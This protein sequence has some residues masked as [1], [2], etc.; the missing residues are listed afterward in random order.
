MTVGLLDLL[1][2][3]LVGITGSIVVN[4]L[5]S[6]S[7]GDRVSNVLEVLNLESIGFENQVIILTSIA[8]FFLILRTL[9]SVFVSQRVLLILANISA[10]TSVKIFENFI[11]SDIRV[12]QEKSGEESQFAIN[13]GSFVFSLNNFKAPIVPRGFFSSRYFIL[14]EVLNSS[15]RYSNASLNA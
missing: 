6:R 13:I 4:G 9:M 11:K 3:I 8:V 15:K 2:L 10:S 7:I 5:S 14:F 1:G 12:I